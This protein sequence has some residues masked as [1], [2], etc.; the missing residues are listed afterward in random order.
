MTSRSSGHNQGLPISISCTPISLSSL[1]ILTFSVPA[2]TTPA[3]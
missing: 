1:A 3:V 2:K